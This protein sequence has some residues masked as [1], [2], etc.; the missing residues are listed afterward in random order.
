MNLETELIQTIDSAFHSAGIEAFVRGLS[1][2]GVPIAS[3]EQASSD[4]TLFLP[5]SAFESGGT[6][7]T[8]F[9]TSYQSLDA[10]AKVCV[11]AHYRSFVEIVPEQLKRKYPRVFR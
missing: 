9:L 10:A 5:G 6:F 11:A 7:T 4:L 8:S 3:M 1:E 2:R